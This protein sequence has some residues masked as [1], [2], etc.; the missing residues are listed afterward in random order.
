[1]PTRNELV[2]LVRR[3]M[4]AEGESQE[5]AD[6]LVEEFRRSVPHPDADELIFYPDRHFGGEPSPE[7]VVDAAMAYRPTEVG[8]A[9]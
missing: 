1:M 9:E 6:A 5:E 3:I 2:E 4:A 8:P 7:E